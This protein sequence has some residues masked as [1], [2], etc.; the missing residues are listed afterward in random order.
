VARDDALILINQD[1]IC[2]TK[3]LNRGDDFFNLLFA[4]G[5]GVFLIRDQIL[6]LPVNDLELLF[7]S[8]H[9]FPMKKAPQR[10][11]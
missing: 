3:L 8:V 4:V 10:T 6:N 2:P 7:V 1:R 5:S 9:V 11:L